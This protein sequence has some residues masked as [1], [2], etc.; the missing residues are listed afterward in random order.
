MVIMIRL[1]YAIRRM[2]VE[3]RYG[4]VNGGGTKI[5]AFTTG[6]GNVIRVEVINNRCL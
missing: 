1:K 2:E 6:A 3:R 4:G 5:E